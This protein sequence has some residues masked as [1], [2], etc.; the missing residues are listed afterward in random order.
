MVGFSK[1]SDQVIKMASG[2]IRHRL[3]GCERR[4][5]LAKWVTVL[6]AEM[7]GFVR[8][9][10]LGLKCLHSNSVTKFSLLTGPVSFGKGLALLQHVSKL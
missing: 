1:S 9:V 7:E 6:K 10:F 8:L 4:L 2:C 5:T 3:A